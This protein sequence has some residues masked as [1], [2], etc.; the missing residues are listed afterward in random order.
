MRIVQVANFVKADSGGIRRCIDQLRS[1]YRRRGHHVTAVVPKTDDRTPEEGIT[2]VPGT[3]VPFT[4]G[5]RAIVARRPLKDLIT[6]LRPDVV[7]LSDKTTL[8]WLPE[9]LNSRGIASVVISH[10][11]TDIVV[12][13]YGPSWLPITS[14]T[15]RFRARVVEFADVIV[16]ASEFAAA[17]FNDDEPRP[18]QIHLVPLGVDLD[19]FRPDETNSAQVG[20]KAKRIELVMC[21]RLSPEKQTLEALRGAVAFIKHHDAHLTVIGDGPLRLELQEL[22]GALPIDFL[23]WVSETSEVSAL[24]ARADVAIN[25]GP[26]ETFGLATLEA[27]ACGVPVV[28]SSTGGSRELV[29]AECGRTVEPTE[30]AVSQAIE[31]LI[32][33]PRAERRAAARARAERFTWS[34]TAESLLGL[35]NEMCPRLSRT[36]SIR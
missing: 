32:A 7:E 20:S 30:T 17:E 9:W 25:L 22:A 11:R 34:N 12:S 8:A 31:E 35:Y 14:L 15:S 19:T 27:L 28:V 6:S 18:D 21:G 26:I 33:I 10:E 2:T 36:E 3:I 4:G 1:E 23:G 29:T 13:R 16:C 5:Y 24:I